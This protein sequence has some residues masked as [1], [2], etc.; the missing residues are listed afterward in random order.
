MLTI[1]HQKKWKLKP[2]C[3]TTYSNTHLIQWLKTNKWD[4]KSWQRWEHSYTAG[5]DVKG[6]TTLGKLFGCFLWSWIYPQPHNPEI[7][8][9]YLLKWKKENVYPQKTYTCMAV[10]SLL[11]SVKYWKQPTCPSRCE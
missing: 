9:R 10:T 3:N 2:Q 6:T 4:S 8:L 11:I 5:G 7:S 1:S